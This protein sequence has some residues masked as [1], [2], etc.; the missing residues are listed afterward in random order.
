MSVE[1]AWPLKVSIN[2]IGQS[3]NQ[4]TVFVQRGLT[5]LVGPNGTGKTRALRAIKS[6]VASVRGISDTGRK[7]LLL[8]AGRTSPMERFRSA[9]DNPSYIPLEDAAVGH[10]GF[11]SQWWNL[12]SITGV[13][14]ALNQRADLRL[15]VEARLQQLFDRSIEL[16]W[17]QAGLTVA[18]SPMLGGSPYAANHEA[19]GVLQLIALLAA[20]HNDDIGALLIDEPE[21]SLHPQHQAFVLEEMQRVAGDPIDPGKKLIVI[22]T[23]SAALMQFRSLSELPSIAFFSSALR[24]PAQVDASDEILKRSKLS[25]LM[26]RLSATHRM[27]VFAERVLLVEGPSDEII[28]S[29]LASR[30][31]QRLLA[32]NAQ[33][34]PVT[35]K[36]EFP[37]VAKLFRLMGKHVA[38]LADLDALADDNTLVRDFSDLPDASSVAQSIGRTSLADLDGDLRVDLSKF[39]TKHETAVDAAAS[40]YDDWSSSGSKSPSVRR[41][42][43][44]RLLTKPNSF[45]ESAVADA[46]GLRTRY[47]VLLEALSRLGCFFLTRGAIE[48]YYD[49]GVSD[50]S[51]PDRAAAVAAKFDSSEPSDLESNYADVLKALTLVAPNHRVDEDLLLRPKLGAALSAAFLTM[52]P[53]TT[54]EQLN[55]IARATIGSHAGVFILN[56][57]SD[58]KTLRIKV[59]IASS[60]FKRE[61]FPF[62]IGADENVNTV[63]HKKLPGFQAQ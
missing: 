62:D 9:V 22:A 61:S 60:L 59:D 18:I 16:N 15:K 24:A 14:L 36:G 27:A 21:I 40:A 55:A 46:S 5:T 39:I 34:L 45:D 41:V 1:Q 52:A 17:S 12:E 44:A 4:G 6:A 63:V 33:I 28:A 32:R 42:T 31:N 56:N 51:K 7:V 25:A 53:N 37:E 10:I 48:N 43:L 26:A 49:D 57:C 20:I 30:M 2:L 47:L 58:E 38:V 8:A 35:G 19:S 29:Q 13:L 3:P 54:D 23:H 11:Q 50:K